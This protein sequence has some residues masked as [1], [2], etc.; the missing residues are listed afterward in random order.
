M[1]YTTMFLINQKL[2]KPGEWP[3]VGI[4]SMHA[5]SLN[6]N[7]FYESLNTNYLTVLF[8]TLALYL[9]FMLMIL[10]IIK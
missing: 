7:D 10:R 1:F 2:T 5:A 9:F 6:V 8:F 3:N 4:E